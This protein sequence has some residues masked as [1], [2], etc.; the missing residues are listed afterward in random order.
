MAS[1]TLTP[2]Q[3][4]FSGPEPLAGRFPKCSGWWESGPAGWDLLWYVNGNVLGEDW[5]K[6]HAL[7]HKPSPPH[8]SR[9][10]MT[11]WSLWYHAPS[12]SHPPPVI[13]GNV[14]RIRHTQ[15]VGGGS[16]NHLILGKHFFLPKTKCA[17]LLS[18]LLLQWWYRGPYSRLKEALSTWTCWLIILILNL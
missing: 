2:L 9:I 1:L 18:R 11:R 10:T 13:V 12:E 17:S 16:P 8:T 4:F 3:H 15:V 6:R 5:K 7:T 14:L